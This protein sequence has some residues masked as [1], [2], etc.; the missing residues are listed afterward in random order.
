MV[1]LKSDFMYLLFYGGC[2]CQMIGI[3][4]TAVLAD[5]TAVEGAGEQILSMYDIEILLRTACH[6]QQMTGSVNWPKLWNVMPWH[7]N[8]CMM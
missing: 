4:T 7:S 5:K 1:M 3:D 2:K 6:Q 8:C